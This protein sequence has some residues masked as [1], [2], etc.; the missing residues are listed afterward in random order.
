[1]LVSLTLYILYNV[2]HGACSFPPGFGPSNTPRS[3]TPC[4]SHRPST[5]PDSPAPS[6]H[7]GN[8]GSS[9]SYQHGVHIST[10]SRH[11]CSSK[12]RAGMCTLNDDLCEHDDALF[13]V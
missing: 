6:C 8:H 11:Y 12:I 10:E 1:M 4:H 3:H 5:C 7:C 9:I 13:K 2:L